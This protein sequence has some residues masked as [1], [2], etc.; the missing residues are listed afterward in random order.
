MGESH[1]NQIVSETLPPFQKTVGQQNS[2]GLPKFRQALIALLSHLSSGESF[3]FL[4]HPILFGRR[5]MK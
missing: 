5:T 4:R 3:L 1:D 2:F